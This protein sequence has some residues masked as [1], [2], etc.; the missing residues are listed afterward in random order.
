VL[1]EVN[2][3]FVVELEDL[4]C[5][6]FTYEGHDPVVVGLELYLLDYVDSEYW[7]FRSQYFHVFVEK[8]EVKS[9]IEVV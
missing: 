9:L 6:H 4:Q 2:V 7:Y 5:W 1:A 8:L 3:L